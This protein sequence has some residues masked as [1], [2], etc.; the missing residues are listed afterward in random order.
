MVLFDWSLF[1]LVYESIELLFGAIVR[2]CFW[3]NRGNRFLYCTG[4]G[5]TRVFVDT[6]GL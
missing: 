2:V 5:N 3:R 4:G 1:N 6:G